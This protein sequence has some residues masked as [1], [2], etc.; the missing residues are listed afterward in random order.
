ME[1]SRVVSEICQGIYVEW[2]SVVAAVGLGEFRWIP[3]CAVALLVALGS[4]LWAVRLVRR[5]GRFDPRAR[6]VVPLALFAVP[7]TV[8][9]VGSVRFL[10]VGM[11]AILPVAAAAA[12]GLVDAV[13]ER[14]RV[15]G[16]LSRPKFVEYASGRFWVTVLTG[17]SIVL[18]PL[19]A[20]SAANGAR[21]PEARVAELLP[22]GC[23]LFSDPDSAGPII[24]TRPD[25][26]VWIDGR[27]DFY[28]RQHLIDA[29]RT[30]AAIDPMPE[31]AN[32]ALLPLDAAPGKTFLLAR[33]LDSDPAW[34]RM[35]TL[36]GYA[37][38]VRR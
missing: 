22:E 36:D 16:S 15:G 9:G 32:C 23:S 21:P 30:Y 13:H 25:V 34:D 31:G 10:A 11:L 29:K 24:L 1:R 2:T 7:M 35:A 8:V 26:K 20:I 33:A 38:W 28:G 17:V 3:I 18:A 12:T 37:L 4:G 6:L 27:A 14:Q 5:N 19:A